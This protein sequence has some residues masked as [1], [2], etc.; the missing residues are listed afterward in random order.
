[1]TTNG[2]DFLQQTRYRVGTS[3]YDSYDE[4]VI[5]SIRES[6]MTSG[7]S[8]IEVIHEGIVTHNTL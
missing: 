2:T 4:A 1:M 8:H 5:A 7:S 6:Q 3:I